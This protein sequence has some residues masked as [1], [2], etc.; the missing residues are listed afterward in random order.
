MTQCYMHM[1]DENSSPMDVM[2]QQ[3]SPPHSSARQ[4]LLQRQEQRQQQRLQKAAAVALGSKSPRRPQ[5]RGTSQQQQ[6][7]Q[8]PAW[9][10]DVY[11][12]PPV[13][14]LKRKNAG[15]VDAWGVPAAGR[16]PT[17]VI[18]YTCSLLKQA[19]YTHLLYSDVDLCDDM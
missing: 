16:L 2:Q 17:G 6:Q 4:Q 9:Q 3:H 7:R 11:V 15:Y 1:Q 10:S 13:Q 5:Q 12:P 8:Q 19:C 18:S 14:L